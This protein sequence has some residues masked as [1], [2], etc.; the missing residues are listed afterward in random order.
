MDFSFRIKQAAGLRKHVSPTSSGSSAEKS[1]RKKGM[2]GDCCKQCWEVTFLWKGREAAL[3]WAVPPT[4]PLLLGTLPSPPPGA[5]EGSGLSRPWAALIPT[6]VL[7]MSLGRNLV[8]ASLRRYG[9]WDPLK[10]RAKRRCDRDRDSWSPLRPRL[11]PPWIS[12]CLRNKVD[13]NRS[14]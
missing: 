2:L 1:V 10:T 4:S 7:S 8:Q 13:R 11:N 12:D 3:F 5:F 9:V 14:K 6:L